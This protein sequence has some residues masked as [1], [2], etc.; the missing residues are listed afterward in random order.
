M[1]TKKC[2]GDSLVLSII[3]TCAVLSG[4]AGSA[5]VMKGQSEQLVWPSPPDEPR[6][7]FEVALGMESSIINE[8]T[9]DRLKRSVTGRVKAD[10]PV[11]DKPSGI[12]VREG[13][14][15]LAE[16]TAR[17]VTV[18]DAARGKVYRFGWREPNQLERPQAIALDG[19]GLVYVLDSSLRRVMVFDALG[20]FQFHI[21]VDK[22][23]SNPVAVAVSPDGQQIYVV[24]RG[25]LGN[26][27]HKV[28][29]F[30]PDGIE[31]FR[32][33]P[34]GSA[35]GFF[36]IPIAATVS[37]DGTLLVADSGNSKIQ[38][39]DS[40]GK[41][42]FSFGGMGS[43]LGRFS[44]PRAISTDSDGN[45]YVA[46]AGFNNIQIFNSVGQLLMPIGVLSTKPGPG[47]Y[48]LIGAIT[49]DERNRLFVTDNY[50]K[51]IDVFRRFE[52]KDDANSQ[53]GSK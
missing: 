39:F 23:F 45:I 8:S 3:M 11:L 4:C 36:N 52:N 29:A 12:A 1:S 33:G 20:L 7:V 9:S 35:D 22:G 42:K 43:E 50:F 6:F 24:D 46:D 5:P 37:A 16:P 34:R 30:G 19:A 32:M 47:N 51:K 40:R 26:S 25:D 28:V 21:S 18:L 14:V 2:F 13:R 49:L 41:F 17:A 48:S 38:A 27:D 10:Q 15:Y 53:K 31:K 44:R